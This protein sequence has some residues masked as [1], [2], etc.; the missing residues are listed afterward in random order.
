[1]P[2]ILVSGSGS[3]GFGGGFGYTG[4]ESGIS[5]KGQ[6]GWSDL[7]VPGGIGGGFG[8]IGGGF[9]GFGLELARKVRSVDLT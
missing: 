7:A 5:L 3:V 8:A 9:G 4:P 2:K 1:M 6:I